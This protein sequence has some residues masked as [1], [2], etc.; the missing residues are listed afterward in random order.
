VKIPGLTLGVRDR[1]DIDVAVGRDFV[2]E[3]VWEDEE[4]PVAITVS[5]IGQRSGVS[6]IRS[7]V[8]NTS[9]SRRSP[10]PGVR[11]L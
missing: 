7:A 6:Q 9:S 8:S 1:D 2:A 5:S 4:S 11:P 3:G 10:A